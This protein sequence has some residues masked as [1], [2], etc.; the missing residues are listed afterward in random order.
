MT[1]TVE[2]NYGQK[3][4]R[5]SVL[6]VSDDSCQTTELK[7]KLEDDGCRV[8][9]ATADFGS[10]TA[11]LLQTYFDLIVLD[12][13]YSGWDSIALINKLKATSHFAD[14]PVVVLVA[15]EQL[16]NCTQSALH[17]FA[18]YWLTKDASVKAGLL[19]VIEQAH[20]MA[21]RYM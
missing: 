16:K 17:N 1:Q 8:Y 11:M 2:Y 12:L 15:P 5:P 3:T 10:L 7:Q 9:C 4:Y 20:Y 14:I 21:Y 19:Q 18:L 6:V 13:E